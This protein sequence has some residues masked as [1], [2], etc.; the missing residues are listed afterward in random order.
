MFEFGRMGWVTLGLG[1]V[2][3]A[4]AVA[5]NNPCFGGRPCSP[6]E[7]ALMFATFSIPAVGVAFILSTVVADQ[8]RVEKE[9]RII[10]IVILGVLGFAVMVYIGFT[11]FPPLI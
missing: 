10:N 5:L 9:K 8:P 4:V 1:L 11:A 6:G 7:N 2:G 3:A